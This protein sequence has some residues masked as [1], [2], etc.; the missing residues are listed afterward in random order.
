MTRIGI[1]MLS[2]AALAGA[3]SVSLAQDYPVKPV[4]WLVPFAPGGS[5]DALARVMAQGLTEAL[6]QQVVVE[7]RP[8]GN[9]IIA[10]LAV[11]KAPADGYTVLQ[12][13]DSTVTLP[14]LYA[15]QPLKPDTHLAPVGILVEQPRLLSSNPKNV[16]ATNLQELIAYA[17]AQPGRINLGVGTGLGQL[18]AELLLAATGTTMTIVPFK[19]GN[20]S[21]I[22]LLA[23]TIDLALGEITSNIPNIK[24]GKIRA[25]ATT[26][27]K[28]AASLPDVPTL[29]ELGYKFTA[30]SWFGLLAPAGT[31]RPV[32]LRLNQEAN[33]ILTAAGPHDRLLAMGMEPVTGT[34]EQ[35]RDMIRA[36]TDQWS[37]VIREKGI[38][39]E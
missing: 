31:P 36:D 22:A 32:V 28:R 11:M 13:V 35:F 17:K 15:D 21:S 16:P 23:G 26:Q 33:R 29:T 18:T 34:P 24:A 19:G 4:R 10:A 14:V 7:N 39:I 1:A 2:L 25:I 8:G 30:R 5:G 20:Q 6:A 12:A 37:R 3:P 27:A 9:T 38:R